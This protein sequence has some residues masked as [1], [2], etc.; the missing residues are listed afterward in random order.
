MKA[1]QKEKILR[2]LLMGKGVT[3]MLALRLWGVNRL[4]SRI[5]ELRDDGYNIISKPKVVKTRNGKAV[6]SEYRLEV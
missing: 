1:S 5:F 3:P 2:W 6:V 4:A